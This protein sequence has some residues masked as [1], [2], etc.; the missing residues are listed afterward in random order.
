MLASGVAHELNNPLA[1]LVSNLGFALA[2][3]SLDPEVAAA[4]RDANDAAA[5]VSEIV[6]DLRPLSRPPSEAHGLTHLAQA[7][8]LALRATHSRWKCGVSVHLHLGAMPTVL[9]APA[10]VAQVLINLIEN[11]CHALDGQLLPQPGV[12]LVCGTT[13]C[14]EAFVEVS[15]NGPGVPPALRARIFE[16]FFTTRGDRHGTGLGLLVA[17]SI[18]SSHGG[19]LELLERAQGST[20][21]LVIPGR[22]EPVA[23]R[24]PTLFW[25]GPD[26][27]GRE[28]VTLPEDLSSV[29]QLLS[30]SPDRVVMTASPESFEVLRACESTALLLGSPRQGALTVA[31]GFDV[32][33]LAALARDDEG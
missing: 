14:G 21:R 11:A 19:S 30:A 15:D 5:R 16:P 29:T 7:V 2:D 33:T 22:V 12:A 27:P 26:A 28:W 25:A 32:A 6:T 1:V 23:P 24:S 9:A 3:P 17:R 20:F 31:P 8:G 10:R 4:L 13:A 18:A